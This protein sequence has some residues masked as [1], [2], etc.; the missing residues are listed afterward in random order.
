LTSGTEEEICPVW[1]HDGQH[2]VFSS[3]REG[4]ANIFWQAA[5]GSGTPERLTTSP[6]RQYPSS[7]SPDG[8]LIFQEEAPT[9]DADLMLL[10]MSGTDRAARVT[11]FLHES[12]RE[13]CGEISPDG[14]WLAYQ[15]NESGRNEIYVR[16]FPVPGERRW[17]VSVGGGVKP[18]WARDGRELFY[19]NGTSLMSVRVETTPVFSAANPTKMFDGQYFAGI[20]GRTYDV[21]LDGKRFLMIKKASTDTTA[22]PA[23]MVVVL[24]WTEELREKLKK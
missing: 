17:V 10:T 13:V 2:L 8:E 14:H 4:V 9:T 3:T 11:P 6:N 1:T 24:N 21:S 20:T 22:T 15:S 23:D 18:L 19:L 7:I 5:D 16:P 12:Y